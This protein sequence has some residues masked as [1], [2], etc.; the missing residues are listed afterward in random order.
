MGINY[1]KLAI[2]IGLDVIGFIP[3]PVFSILWAPLSAYIMTK[4]YTGK[5]G[6]VAGVISFLEELLPIDIV[7]TFTIM[8][9]YTHLINKIKFKN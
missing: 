2:S 5:K 6:K 9:I 1:K 8:W 4:M 3:F 7:P